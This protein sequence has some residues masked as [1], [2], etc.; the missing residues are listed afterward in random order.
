[1]D[2]I[3]ALSSGRPPAAIAVVRISGAAACAAGV[4]LVGRLPDPRTASLRTVRAPDG[5]VL[6]QALVLWFPGPQTAT[7]EDL[8]ELHLHGGRAVVAAVEQALGAQSGLR[9][10]LPGEFTRRALHAGRIDLAQAE[11]LADLLEAETEM[12]RRA[13]IGA[14]EG[15]VSAALGGWLDRLASIAATIE[16]TLDFDDEGD[17]APAAI[18]AIRQEIAA[19]CVEVTAMLAHPSVERLRD[20]IRI[21][22]AGPPNAGKS[23]LFNA[24]VDRDAA[25]VTPVAGTTRDI[26]EASVVRRG[27]PYT[28]IDTAG[29]ATDTDDAIEAIGIQRAQIAARSADLVLWLGDAAAPDDLPPLIAVHAQNDRP[30]RGETPHDRVAVSVGSPATIAALWDVIEERSATLLGQPGVVTLRDVQRAVL[31]DAIA[32]LSRCTAEDDPILI[33]EAVRSASRSVARLLGKDATEAM[34]DRLFA[35]FCIGK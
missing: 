34:L 1:M 14:V 21:V 19:W 5:V 20:G 15:A 2:T 9:P 32:L 7:G 13:A 4:A 16:A 11:G 22:L 10:A 17:V 26:I 12:Q 18:D 29:L 6:D 35:R 8:V 23:S 3:F 31:S 28:I 24:L 27:M 33:A 25:I 30:G